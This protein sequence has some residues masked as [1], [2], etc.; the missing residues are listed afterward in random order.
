MVHAAG[1]TISPLVAGDWFQ[2]RPTGSLG[3]SRGRR[4]KYSK[5][6]FIFVAAAHASSK[7]SPPHDGRSKSFDSTAIFRHGVGVGNAMRWQSLTICIL[8]L[9]WI[10]AALVWPYQPHWSYE[11][12]VNAPFFPLSIAIPLAIGKSAAVVLPLAAIYLCFRMD[13]EFAGD[14]MTF[15]WGLAY[16][17]TGIVVLLALAIILCAPAI[18]SALVA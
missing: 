10:P 7:S 6:F 8:C 9:L 2:D 5:G 13:S 16:V 17:S 15:L 1:L 12:E 14:R 18:T 11:L 3:L 4:R